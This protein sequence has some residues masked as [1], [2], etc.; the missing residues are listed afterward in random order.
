MRSGV[1]SSAWAGRQWWVVRVQVLMGAADATPGPAWVRWVQQAT[2][3]KLNAAEALTAAAVVGLSELVRGALAARV[4]LAGAHGLHGG[5]A[6]PPALAR[7]E[8]LLGAGLLHE[9]TT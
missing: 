8:H 7:L 1:H 9:G 5:G 2:D 6:H 4:V 3:H